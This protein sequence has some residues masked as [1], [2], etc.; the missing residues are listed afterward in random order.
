MVMAFLALG[1]RRALGEGPARGVFG[2]AELIVMQPILSAPPK[3]VGIVG[4]RALNPADIF[5]YELANG[6]VL[7]PAAIV[8][9]FEGGNPPL[10]LQPKRYRLE[11]VLT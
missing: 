1:S 5:A 9:F 2:R 10:D 4:F 11:A 6:I 8:A 3:V 7:K